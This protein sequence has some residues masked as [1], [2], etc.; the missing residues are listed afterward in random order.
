MK[1][2][3]VSA[4]S[5]AFAIGAVSTV[6]AVQPATAMTQEQSAQPGTDGWI[7]TKVKTELMTNKGIPSND[8]SVT[9]SNG[10]VTLTGILD[11]R[12]Q[13]QQTVAVAKAVKGVQR[14]DSSGLTARKE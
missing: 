7:T 8:I 11:T 1:S 6:N 10:V 2:L 14:V 12:E 13:V 9:T 4:M 5:L 3:L